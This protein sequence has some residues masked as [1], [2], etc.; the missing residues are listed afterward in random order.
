[1]PRFA[2]VFAF[3]MIVVA[4]QAVARAEAPV[5]AVVE[6]TLATA[7][8]RIRQF[9]FDGDDAT[10]YETEAAGEGDHAVALT[11]DAPVQ[12]GSVE[13][14][15]GDDGGAGRLDVGSLEGSADGKAFEKLADFREGAAKAEP[16]RK[17]KAV[18]VV[19]GKDAKG[20]LVVREFLVDSEPEVRRFAYPVEI[21]VDELDAP[22][23]RGWA[24]K[25]ARE[26]ER[27]YDRINEALKSD[28]YRPAR[29]IRMSLKNDIDVP[30]YAGGGR[31]TGSV[32]WFKDHPDD[33]GAMIHETAHIVQR[34]RGRRNPNPGW[35]VEGVADYVRFVLYEPENIGGLNPER[36]K[37]DDSYRVTARFLDYVVKKYDPDFVLKVNRAMREGTY[38]DDLFKQATGKPKEELGAEWKASL[39]K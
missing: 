25:A 12:V 23:M 31:I 20:P 26:C 39:K 34:Y 38:S 32:K 1:M 29:V 14:R 33:V 18:R 6:S 2:F 15:T 24:E 22:G 16:G 5:G 7:G 13:V 17:L 4:S 21:V 28:G 37:Y 8:E 19:P 9:A 27:F 3:P 30:A 11:F 10:S 35:L 36:A